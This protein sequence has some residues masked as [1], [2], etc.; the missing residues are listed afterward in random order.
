MLLRFASALLVV[1][2]AL[3][4][5]WAL[6]AMADDP[7]RALAVAGLAL[8][9]VLL[10]VLAAGD[11]RLRIRPALRAAALAA[12]AVMLLGVLL[13]LRRLVVE[14]IPTVPLSQAAA[15]ADFQRVVTSL[16]VLGATLA[17]VGLGVVLLRGPRAA[18]AAGAVPPPEGD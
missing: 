4:I 5:L 15:R 9:G 8:I 6:R 18:D 1:L 12:V 11:V 17:Y 13:G 14:V 16:Q 10:H 2:G 3:P 7:R